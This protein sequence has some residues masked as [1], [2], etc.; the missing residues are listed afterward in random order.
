MTKKYH[1]SRSIDAAPQAVWNL[2]TDASTYDDWNPAVL[3]IRGP[4]Q[5]GNTIELVSSISP[6]RTFK[7]KVQS[8]HA[9]SEMVW[10]SGMP[11][12]LFTGTR[13][14]RITPTQTGSTFSMTEEFSGPLSGLITKSIP[15]MTESF[16]H[17][18]D[19]LKA[20]AEA[21]G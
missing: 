8:M 12:G 11:L 14:Y 6:T 7:L 18:A 13:T 20:A 19:G 9:P 5:T 17:F 15:D 2:L 3:R 10:S 1:V 16:D 4:I 21:A